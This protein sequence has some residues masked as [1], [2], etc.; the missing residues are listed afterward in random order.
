[1]INGS[2]LRDLLLNSK[3]FCRSMPAGAENSSLSRL[4]YRKL[5]GSRNRSGLNSRRE[6]LRQFL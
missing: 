5:W 1:M 4:C 2:S 6:K 3:N